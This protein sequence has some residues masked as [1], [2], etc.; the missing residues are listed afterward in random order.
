MTRILA[1]LTL[2]LVLASCGQEDATQAPE[3]GAEDAIELTLQSRFVEELPTYDG[4]PLPEGLEWVTNNEDPV[5]S[6]PE[7]TRGGT[8]NT[9]MMSFPL[10][11]RTVGPDANDQFSAYKRYTNLG[12][13]GLHPNTLRSR[14]KRLG[15]RRPAHAS[16]PA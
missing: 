2:S 13:V 7:A 6:S 8:F 5:W 4:V 11:L 15:L 1:L 16:P 9:F 12:L 10:T 3:A 14:M